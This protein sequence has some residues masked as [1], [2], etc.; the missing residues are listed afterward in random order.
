MMMMMMT[1]FRTRIIPTWGR[2]FPNFILNFIKYQWHAL[3]IPF[4][5]QITFQFT[6]VTA[7]V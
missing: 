7:N 5:T 3:K 4:S 6:D 2:I 1:R